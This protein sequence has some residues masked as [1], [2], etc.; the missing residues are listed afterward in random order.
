MTQLNPWMC[1]E[2]AQ[3]ELCRERCVPKFLK[4]SSKVSECRP[5]S[6]GPEILKQR[7]DAGDREAQYSL[8]GAYTRSLFSS[9]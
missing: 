8:V 4:L 7:A 2:C 9:T 6:T 5:L 1:P 3:V